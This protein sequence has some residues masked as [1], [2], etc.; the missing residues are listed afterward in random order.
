[1]FVALAKA[2]GS[3]KAVSAA[4]PDVQRVAASNTKGSAG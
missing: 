4:V 1:M 3:A 2:L